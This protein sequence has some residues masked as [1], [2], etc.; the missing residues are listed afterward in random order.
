MKI[1]QNQKKIGTVH[2]ITQAIAFIVLTKGMGLLFLQA[3]AESPG[4][5]MLGLWIA[6]NFLGIVLLVNITDKLFHNSTSLLIA[7]VKIILIALLAGIISYLFELIYYKYHFYYIG[8]DFDLND[9]KNSFWSFM[10]YIPPV[11]AIGELI[12]KNP[13]FLQRVRNSVKKQKNKKTN[14]NIV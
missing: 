3:L 14:A 13:D 9:F 4:W 6:F 5:V 10:K 2:F 11:V 7:G 12:R 8:R 1:L